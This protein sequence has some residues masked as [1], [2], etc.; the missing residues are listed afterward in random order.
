M[1]VISI[2]GKVMRNEDKV[3]WFKKIPCPLLAVWSS[4]SLVSEVWGMGL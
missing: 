2:L 3:F 1:M 4:S